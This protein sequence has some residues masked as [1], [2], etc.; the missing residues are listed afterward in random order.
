MLGGCKRS[1]SLALFLKQ[2]LESWPSKPDLDYYNG[3]LVVQEGCKRFFKAEG[4]LD[5]AIGVC[6]FR[7]HCAHYWMILE[8]FLP[9]ANERVSTS[10]IPIW[11]IEVLRPQEFEPVGMQLAQISFERLF[12]RTHSRYRPLLIPERSQGVAWTLNLSP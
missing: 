3:G 12:R 8:N 1:Q 9:G 7:W 11:R 6:E 5:L 4:V 2:V 10:F